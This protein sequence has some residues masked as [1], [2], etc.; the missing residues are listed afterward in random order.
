LTGITRV[1]YGQNASDISLLGGFI[2]FVGDAKEI[3]EFPNT[4]A[5]F[6]KL[7]EE[8]K[9][10]LK[11]NHLVTH[12]KLNIELT[13][14]QLNDNINI[15]E[16]QPLSI[17]DSSSSTL[18]SIKSINSLTK[19]ESTE[20]YDAVIIATP[21]EFSSIHI[22]GYSPYK[23]EYRKVYV[24]YCHG[25]INHTRFGLNENSLSGV[26][27]TDK[28]KLWN[29]IGV[30]HKF[31]DNSSI[32]KLFSINPVP[33]DE[34]DR[35]FIKRYSTYV[36]FW[37]DGSYP[38]L[39]PGLPIPPLILKPNLFYINSFESFISV[40]EGSVVT[41]KNVIRILQRNWKQEQ[42]TLSSI[43]SKTKSFLY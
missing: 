7:V 29:S 20:E 3:F 19:A 13:E 21:L 16:N 12:V 31:E 18:Y 10:N 6:E 25:E 38:L 4:Q 8:S 14:E 34:L 11:L 42:C 37:E 22:D 1:I 15:L 35:I 30:R 39:K 43:N 32:I 5:V 9:V 41:S 28:A 27:T 26:L 36:H 23:R 17:I 40:L 24:T 33:E 2:S